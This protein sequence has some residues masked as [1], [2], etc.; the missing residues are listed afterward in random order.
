M[1][2][3]R[4]RWIITALYLRWSIIEWC[5]IV[6]FKFLNQCAP[7]H[8]IQRTVCLKYH[9]SLHMYHWY[10]ISPTKLCTVPG[11][12]VRAINRSLRPLR[13]HAGH[14]EKLVWF[15]AADRISPT[16]RSIS[17]TYIRR[18]SHSNIAFNS[19]IYTVHWSEL[20]ARIRIELPNINKTKKQIHLLTATQDDYIL[21]QQKS[22]ICYLCYARNGLA[23]GFTF[24]RFEHSRDFCYLCFESAFGCGRSI[25]RGRDKYAY[26][27]GCVFSRWV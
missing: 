17:F 26:D 21:W 22:Y 1:N 2:I 13:T 25:W 6:K 12:L 19:T 8:L 20:K 5:L 15:Y 27:N 14:A 3:S 7:T 9:D 24:L 16:F 18:S 4:S 23:L 11:T 10:A